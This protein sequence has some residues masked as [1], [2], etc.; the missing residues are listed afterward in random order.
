MDTV[1]FGDTQVTY[2]DEEIQ[3]LIKSVLLN[4]TPCTQIDGILILE[5]AADSAIAVNQT[6]MKILKVFGPHV[7]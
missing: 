3:D 1:G 7:K 4:D 5:N 6:Y 2:T